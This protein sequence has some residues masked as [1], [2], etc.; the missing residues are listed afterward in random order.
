MTLDQAHPALTGFVMK[1]HAE[2]KRLVLVIT[3]KGKERDELT[4]MPT[5][6]GVLRH[7]VPAWLR[8]PPLSSVVIQV[9]TAHQRHGGIGAYYVY[10]RRK[11]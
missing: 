4:S 1:A 11:R 6:R 2:G 8:T 9:D 3:G 7:N 5:R 10:L